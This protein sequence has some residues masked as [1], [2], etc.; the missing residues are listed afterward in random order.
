MIILLVLD[1][2]SFGT[3]IKFKVFFETMIM[4]G[5]YKRID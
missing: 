2:E 4:T 3:R 1:S 5:L